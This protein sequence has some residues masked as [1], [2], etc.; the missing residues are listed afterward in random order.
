[1]PSNSLVSRTATHLQRVWPLVLVPVVATLLSVGELATL[2]AN[3]DHEFSVTFGVPR[4]VSTLFSF[5][6][7]IPDGTTVYGLSALDP[8]AV[9]TT[10]ASIVLTGVLAAGYLG[11]ID[12]ALRGEWSF[13]ASLR[14]YAPPFV[15]LALLE[16]G[17]GLLFALVALSSLGSGPVL[18]VFGVGLFALAYLFFTAPYLVVV[19]DRA[20]VAALRGAVT[21]ATGDIRVPAFFLA[22]IALSAVCSVPISWL[23]YTAPPATASSPR[24][25][26]P[27]SRS[28][29]TRPRCCSYA[30]SRARSR[31]RPRISRTSRWTCSAHRSPSTR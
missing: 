28:R 1:M 3:T 5:L 14:R 18:I 13:V 9:A 22:Y 29:S 10:V 6:N 25:S 30:I 8:L 20:L 11:S 23:A 26:V 19:E 27:R 31:R 7:V 15:G 21:L 16:A 12:A 17:V 4:P 24:C 2:L